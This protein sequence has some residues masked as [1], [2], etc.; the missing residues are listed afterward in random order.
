[1]SDATQ[2][3]EQVMNMETEDKP[4]IKG[5]RRSAARIPR[6]VEPEDAFL[7]EPEETNFP[8]GD[9]TF[10]DRETSEDWVEPE[11]TDHAAAEC[12]TE[13]EHDEVC[14]EHPDE[15]PAVD[16]AAGYGDESTENEAYQPENPLMETAEPK[17]EQDDDWHD[18]YMDEHQ[19][20]GRHIH[21]R[22]GFK[23]KKRQPPF[24]GRPFMDDDG[25]WFVVMNDVVFKLVPQEHKEG[26]L[27]K[28][29]M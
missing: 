15:E 14:T 18:P 27:D 22:P 21:G 12:Q 20:H 10:D 26:S 11:T 23:M 2:H 9:T 29:S 8:E 25:Q 28:F 6:E 16:D 24:P 3:E 13:S 17:R 1:M 5:K 19:Y 7:K 4:V